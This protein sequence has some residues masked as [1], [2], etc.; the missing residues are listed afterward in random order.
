[1]MHRQLHYPCTP[2]CAAPFDEP[3]HHLPHSSSVAMA[4][5]SLK[6]RKTLSGEIPD[7]LLRRSSSALLSRVM[8]GPELA[9][10]SLSAAGGLGVHRT[11]PQTRSL[12]QSILRRPRGLISSRGLRLH[13][14]RPASHRRRVP[15]LERKCAG[16]RG[17]RSRSYRPSA[18][19]LFARPARA[20]AI[21]VSGR[22]GSGRRAAGTQIW[23]QVGTLTEAVDAA[24]SSSKPDVTGDPGRRGRRPRAGRRRHRICITLLPEVADALRSADISIP[25]FAAGGHCRWPWSSPPPFGLGAAGAVMGT[26]VS[27]LEGGAHQAWLPAGGSSCL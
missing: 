23:G 3:S 24:R 5:Q 27:R 11:W 1:M 18:A 16:R 6:F 20:G 9:G 15:D 13:Q 22:T 21:R 4:P 10:G 14:R 19:W 2:S 12:E 8:S 17:G 25:I 7:G 26:P